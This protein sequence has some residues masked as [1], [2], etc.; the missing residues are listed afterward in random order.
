LTESNVTFERMKVTI[1]LCMQE[2][3]RNEFIKF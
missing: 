1:Q 3:V 2:F